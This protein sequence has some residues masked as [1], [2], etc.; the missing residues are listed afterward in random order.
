LRQDLRSFAVDAI[1]S[2]EMVDIAADEVAEAELNRV[3][4]A[5][6]G[7]FSGSQTE[8][9]K[10]KFGPEQARWVMEEQWHPQQRTALEP[11]GSLI[12]ELP[13]ANPTELVMD[14][15]RHGSGVEVLAPQELRKQVQRDLE[16]A[17]RCYTNESD[18]N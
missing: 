13:Y 15:L 3:L 9:A 5:G 7:I 12:L 2:A 4:A 14:I 16:H 8:W 17:L 6:Y 1:R 18:G 10:L 11:D